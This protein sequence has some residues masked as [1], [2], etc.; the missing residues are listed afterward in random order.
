VAGSQL[1]QVLIDSGSRLNLLFASTLKKMGLG[2]SKMLS[3]SRA[4]F[5][6]IIPKNAATPLGSMVLPVTFRTKDNYRTKYIKFEV[7]DFESSY[8]AI[9]DR[10]ALAKLPHC[11]CLLLMMLGVLTF[12]GDLRPRGDR[13]RHDITRARAFRGSLRSRAK[14]HRLRDEISSQRP[15][16]QRVKPNP[17]DVGVKP[18]T[19]KDYTDLNKHCANDF[20]A[21]PLICTSIK[22]SIKKFDF[23][24]QKIFTH[25]HACTQTSD[26]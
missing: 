26:N 25:S 20:F 11:I 21:L 7:A 14:A 18:S 17:S 6:G 10:L 23:Q 24:K 3:P 1:T 2:I 16:Q 13:V 5:Y 4:P 12:H 15:S 8:D 19:C 9:L 22:L